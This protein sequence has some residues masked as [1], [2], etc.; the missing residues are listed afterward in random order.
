MPHCKVKATVTV[1]ITGTAVPFR[2]VGVNSHC[3]T[4][5]SAA[6]S[7]IGI[8]RRTFESTT[9]PLAAIVASMTTVPSTR[10][11]YAVGG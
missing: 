4:P 9:W 6:W 7:S 3:L 2:S 8:E 1:M 10:A 11:S 5:S